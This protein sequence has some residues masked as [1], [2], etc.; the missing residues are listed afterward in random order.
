MLSAA[1][2]ASALVS[3][4]QQCLRCHVSAPFLVIGIGWFW[5]SLIADVDTLVIG[6]W[7]GIGAGPRRL[8]S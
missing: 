7:F 8:W 4:T 5:A 6:L 2:A 3:Q 1:A